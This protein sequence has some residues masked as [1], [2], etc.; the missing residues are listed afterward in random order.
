MQ[1]FRYFLRRRC[2]FF[3]KAIKH[4]DRFAQKDIIKG[5]T[6]LNASPL[7]FYFQQLYLPIINNRP[8]LG[9]LY[10]HS[11]TF[12]ASYAKTAY[13]IPLSLYNRLNHIHIYQT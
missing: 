9:C 13:Y 11:N 2:I 1:I 5:L 12:Y 8:M 7:S 3:T 4:T 10:I 6:S